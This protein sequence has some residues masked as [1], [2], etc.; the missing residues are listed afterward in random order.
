MKNNRYIYYVEGECEEQLINVLK[1]QP[2]K[3]APGKVKKLNVNSLLIPKSEMLGFKQGTI[4]VFVFDTDVPETEKLKKNIELIK[5]YCSKV[6]IIYL[7]QVL[8]FE[9]ELQRATDVN[10]VLDLTHSRS[11][12]NFKSDFAKM[13]VDSCKSMLE[14]HQ[15][16][17]EEMWTKQPRLPF[18]FI[19]QN[20]E[21]I[22]I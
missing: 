4:V 15:L 17:V 7:A 5:R 22:K 2:A 14:R 1:K 13:K 10:N 6:K 21:E 16:R 11:I 19:I 12:S 18:D 3:I 9:D 8:N 20:G